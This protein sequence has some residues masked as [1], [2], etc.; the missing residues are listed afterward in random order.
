[1][2]AIEFGGVTM[3]ELSIIINE[4]TETEQDMLIDYLEKI[5]AERECS[6]CN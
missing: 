3:E 1:M 2:F 6:Q 4:L 5:L